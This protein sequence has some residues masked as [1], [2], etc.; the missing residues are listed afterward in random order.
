M[1][2]IASLELNFALVRN[3]IEGDVAASS[4]TAWG[5][6]SDFWKGIFGERSNFPSVQEFLAFRRADFG[7]G[8]ADERQGEVAREEEHF[9]RTVEIFRQ[10]VDVGQVLALDEDGLGA[11]Y[12][13]ESGGA[14]RSAAFWTNACT[15]LR[16]RDLYRVHGR[17]SQPL[18][19]LEIGAGWGCASH[20]LHQLLDVENYTII[21]LP[22]N[23]FLST[24]YLSATLGRPLQALPIGSSGPHTINPGH[25]AFGL[26]GCVPGIAQKF[27]LI[28]NTFSLQEM[29]LATVQAYF[30]WVAEAL[31]PEGIFVSLNSH[32]KAGV[33]RPSDYPVDAFELCHLGMFRDYPTGMMNTIP[34][35]M[36]LKRKSGGAID[37]DILD[38]IGCLVQ[39]GL[40][41][42][43]KE[44]CSDLA[45]GTLRTDVA[46]GLVAIKGFFSTSAQRRAQSLPDVDAGPLAA[47]SAYLRGMHAFVAG[48]R[49]VASAS[50]QAALAS[51]LKG[52]ARLRA[53]A[54]LSILRGVTTLPEWDTDF[55]ALLAYPELRRMLDES[56]P[57]PFTVQFERIVSANL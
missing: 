34:Y 25:I 40:G 4:A 55:D 17:T 24:N 13:F 35:E 54:H 37:H 49:A 10:S 53:V 21:D 2:S 9:R 26:P 52:F 12:V 56:D 28:V 3:V 30:N 14:W 44:I 45:R 46:N 38:V 50:M 6:T 41:D 23:L 22:E 36:V 27:D 47:I 51:G 16:I 15:A 18:S 5:R 8:M 11:P 29:D 1:I 39:F 33:I 43:L 42:D 57:S 32:G 48:D 20:L 7:Y 19:I 31:S